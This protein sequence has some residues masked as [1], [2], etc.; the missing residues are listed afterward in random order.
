MEKIVLRLDPSK[1]NNDLL[2]R[3]SKKLV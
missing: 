3:D 2:E 1:R